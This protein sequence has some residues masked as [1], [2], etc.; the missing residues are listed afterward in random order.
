MGAL[1]LLPPGFV[2][3][4]AR[5]QPLPRLHLRSPPETLLP[6]PVHKLLTWCAELVG[7]R[8]PWQSAEA[9]WVVEASSGGPRDNARAKPPM[10]AALAVA[11]GDVWL[12]PEERRVGSSTLALPWPCSAAGHP[13]ANPA[14]PVPRS[15]YPS[16]LRPARLPAPALFLP[17]T[18]ELLSSQA[19]VGPGAAHVRPPPPHLPRASCD[20][21]CTAGTHTRALSPAPAGPARQAPAVSVPWCTRVLML[22]CDY[23]IA[24]TCYTLSAWPCPSLSLSLNFPR[25]IFD[26][27]VHSWNWQ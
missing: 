10:S 11:Q 27:L 12:S 2:L 17:S 24:H 3:G 15:C 25:P 26:A 8:C 6:L 4:A 21:G 18:H 19:R 23:P 13:G 14:E 7:K 16:R 1:S 5:L 9:P 22:L 20:L